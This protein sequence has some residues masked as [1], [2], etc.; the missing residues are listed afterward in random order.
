MKNRILLN[1]IINESGNCVSLGRSLQVKNIQLYN[2]VLNETQFLDNKSYVKFNERAYCII[3]NINCLQLDAFNNPA[4]FINIFKG[5]SL[6]N[7]KFKK[8]QR[9]LQIELNKQQRLQV[10][11]NTP[12]KTKLEKEIKRIRRRN[13]ELYQSDM[14]DGYDYVVCPETNLRLC[15]IKSNYITNIL[16]L[17][18]EEYLKKYPTVKLICDKRRENVKKGLHKIDEETG[19]TKY[20]IAQK[21]AKETLSKIDPITGLSGYDKKGQRTKATHMSKLDEY[22][23]NG[24][25]RLATKAII[26]GN[27]TKAEKGLITN[28]IDR[29]IFRRY[30]CIVT[31]LTNK[32]KNDISTGYVIGL[33]GTNN[34]WHIDHRISVF[35]GFKHKISPFVISHK[36]NLQ[37]LPWKE[38]IS[39]HSDCDLK[40]DDLLN[41]INYTFDESLSEYEKII[42]LIKLDISNNVRTNAAFLIERYY[43]SKK[44]SQQ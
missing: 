42:D 30:R 43:E 7:H 4:R 26:K 10:K 33:A 23:R 38:N 16:G 1:D 40:L 37:M 25:S 3:N 27:Q 9:G 2:W 19:L 34:A 31:Y 39:K 32:H 11:S 12:K 6:N 22:G 36:S 8:T 21:K 29:N 13:A 15:M 41:T 17:T 44:C 28:L 35:Y 20:E 18:T 14:I 24:Y 5:Y